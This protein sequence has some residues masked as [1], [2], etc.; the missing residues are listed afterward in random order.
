MVGFLLGSVMTAIVGC[1]YTPW[2]GVRASFSANDLI[3][4]TTSRD[5]DLLRPIR[6]CRQCDY[7]QCGDA[8]MGTTLADT[9]PVG[10]I[11]SRQVPA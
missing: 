1:H 6:S 3:L 9:R 2:T 4:P 5:Q 8:I 7:A 10:K 11:A